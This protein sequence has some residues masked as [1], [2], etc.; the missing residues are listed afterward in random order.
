MRT[1]KSYCKL[2]GLVI[3]QECATLCIDQENEIAVAKYS[4]LHVGTGRFLT[5]QVF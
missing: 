2:L 5:R 1:T 4:E 3:V